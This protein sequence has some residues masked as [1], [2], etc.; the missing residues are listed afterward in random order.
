MYALD[1]ACAAQPRCADLIFAKWAFNTVFEKSRLLIF[2]PE[3]VRNGGGSLLSAGLHTR[4]WAAFSVQRWG[5][6]QW[7]YTQMPT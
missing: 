7:A 4:V 2:H 6:C 3:V 1:P 5:V